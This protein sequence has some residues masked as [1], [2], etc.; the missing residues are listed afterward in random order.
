MTFSF[1]IT[2]S[3][4][5]LYYFLFQ[6]GGLLA[7]GSDIAYNNIKENQVAK[8]ASDARVVELGKKLKEVESAHS[9][10]ETKWNSNL[11]AARTRAKDAEKESRLLKTRVEELKK[12]L[13]ERKDEAGIIAEFKKSQD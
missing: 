10:K 13:A 4:S 9:K 8:K 5:D 12:Q 7:G 2:P 3:F 6:I 1:S 11:Q